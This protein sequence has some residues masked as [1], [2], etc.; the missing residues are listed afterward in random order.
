DPEYQRMFRWSHDQQTQFIESILLN[1]P[2]PPVFFAENANG[3]FE[4]IDGLQ[5]FST[6]L[7]F[8]ASEM[9]PQPAKLAKRAVDMNNNIKVPTTLA[10]GPILSKLKGVTLAT[11]P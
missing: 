8:F 11:M 5:R 3:K 9:F 10:A 6:V 2:T 4:L 7:K 1:I